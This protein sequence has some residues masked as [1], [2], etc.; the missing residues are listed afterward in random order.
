VALGDLAGAQAAAAGALT[1]FE[2]AYGTLHPST[3]HARSLLG[4]F[5]SPLRRGWWR[6][7]AR[8]RRMHLAA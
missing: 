6:T 8:L 7:R 5:S 3:R 1:G 2:R 4:Q